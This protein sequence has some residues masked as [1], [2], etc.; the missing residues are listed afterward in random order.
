VVDLSRRLFRLPGWSAASL[1]LLLLTSGPTRAQPADA[2]AA[3]TA[4]LAEIGRD[5]PKW[6][7]VNA[8]T[9]P[10]YSPAGYQR[11]VAAMQARLYRLRAIP[12]ASL[13]HDEAIALQAAIWNA[14]LIVEQAKYP[15]LR[16]PY[17]RTEF[18]LTGPNRDLEKHRFETDAAAGAYLHLVAQYP[19]AIDGLGEHLRGQVAHGIYLQRDAA[20][21]AHGLFLTLANAPIEQSPAWPSDERLARLSPKAKAALRAKLRP[22]ITGRISPALRRFAEAF[23]ADYLGHAPTQWGLWQYEGGRD[24]YR[25][26]IKERLS[27]D[28]SPEALFQRAQTE[29]DAAQS[30][31]AALRVEMAAAPA[32]AQASPT[33]TPELYQQRMA[34]YMARVERVMPDLFCRKIPYPYEIRRIPPSAESSLTYGFATFVDD[35]QPHGVYYFNGGNLNTISSLPWQTI[36]YHE[37]MPGHFVQDATQRMVPRMRALSTGDDNAFEE[38]WAEYANRLGYEHGLF[39]TAQ[40]RYGRRVFL[41]WPVARAL[42]DLGVNYFGKDVDWARR[43]L[44]RYQVDTAKAREDNLQRDVADWPAQILPYSFGAEEILRLRE[45]AK[46]ELGDRFDLRRFN[47]A[48]LTAGEIPLPVLAK[49]ID[50]FIAQEKQGSARGVC[51]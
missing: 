22:L 33:W 31:M 50:W 45:Q 51:E 25:L 3:L 15:W 35:P 19:A 47:D 21:T 18:S 38:S 26:L 46:L 49:H 32:A 7:A 16:F 34:S 39:E 10:D 24:Y 17:T 48:V 1:L 37:L 6:G 8:T 5:R 2:H 23:D 11:Q 12:S 41:T 14:G 29:L 20:I 42:T 30:D 28:V 44:A 27:L 40:E 4:I 13:D 9:L 36:V 43:L